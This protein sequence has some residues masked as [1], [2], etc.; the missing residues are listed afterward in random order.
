MGPD[1]QE[2][3]NI[4][5]LA[6]LLLSLSCP[7]W[8]GGHTARRPGKCLT[9]GFAGGLFLWGPSPPARELPSMPTTETLP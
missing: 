5:S 3:Q 4:L 1:Y 2:F 7:L 9:Q 6:A 8:A